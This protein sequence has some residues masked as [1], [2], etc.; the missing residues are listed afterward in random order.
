MSVDNNFEDQ[1]HRMLPRRNPQDEHYPNVNSPKSNMLVILRR[2]P[3]SG[4]EEEEDL[5]SQPGES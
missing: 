4:T 5:V 2:S 3:K 1:G